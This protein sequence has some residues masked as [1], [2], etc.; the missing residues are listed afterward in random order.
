MPIP[1]GFCGKFFQT[2]KEK[3]IIILQK[4]KKLDEERTYPN[5]FYEATSYPDR[6]LNINAKIFNKILTN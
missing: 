3:I 5:S 1:N 6:D 4:T 2:F